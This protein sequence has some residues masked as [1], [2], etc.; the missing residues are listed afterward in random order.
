MS[1]VSGITVQRTPYQPYTPECN[2]GT[3][4]CCSFP[5]SQ[6][7]LH[8]D[9]CSETNGI[10]DW[11]Y[12]CDKC[13]F[14]PCKPSCSKPNLDACKLGGKASGNVRWSGKY[15]YLNPEIKCTYNV[16]DITSAD[17]VNKWISKFGKGGDY[18][19]MMQNF[20]SQNMDNCTNGQQSCSFKN[21]NSTEGKMCKFWYNEQ[22]RNSAAQ[23]VVEAICQK[24]PLFPECKCINRANDPLY[25]K[26]KVGG[27]KN[28]NDG[29]W[30]IPCTSEATQF[31]PRDL[32]KPICPDK[33]CQN[34]LSFV[35]TGNVNMTGIQST[36]NC[37]FSG[38]LSNNKTIPA[39]SP[40]Y[41]ETNHFAK[42][43]VAIIH[44]FFNNRSYAIATGVIL[45][46]SF[47]TLIALKIFRFAR[48]SRNKF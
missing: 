9:P 13:S 4:D 38:A 48:Y 35:D 12:K 28:Y 23:T 39:G 16:D 14:G 47:G 37:D 11:K 33:L 42:D 7:F 36:I 43:I 46:I 31:I 27:T 6:P 32:Y 24:N 17:Q 29:C 10:R 21:S 41:I 18:D 20:C 2:G 3:G 19:K 44:N 40:T 45:L 15:N 34:I 30:Y 25:Q 26:F 5:H 1:Q 22:Q 8:F